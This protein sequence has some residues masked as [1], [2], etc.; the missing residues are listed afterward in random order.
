MPA[1]KLSVLAKAASVALVTLSATAAMAQSVPLSQAEGQRLWFVELSGSPVADGNSQ[2]AVRSEKQ[3]LRRAAAAAG[4]SFTERRSF[5]TLFNGLSIEISTENRLKLSRLAGVKAMYPI[6]TIAAPYVEN[7]GGTAPDLASAI[8]MTGAHIAQASGLT[9]AGIKVGII[10]TGVDLQHPAFRKANGESRVVA[11]YDFVGDNYDA[12]GTGSK[13][14]PQPDD[15]PDDC[16]GHGSHVAG[17]VGGNGT[18]NNGVLIKG[19]APD[20]SFGAYRVFGCEGST[21]SDIILAALERAHADG[22][23]VINQSLG[24]G[25]QWPQYPTAQ[26]S[27]RLA[28][29][30]VVMVASIGNN[31]PGGG[32]PDGLFAAGAP[33]V[34]DKVIGVASFDNTVV[35]QPAFTV[36]PGNQ[37]IGFTAG[38]VPIPTSGSLPMAKT[39]TTTTTNDGCNAL[40][41]GSM[42]G[43][44]VLIR[45]GTC[46]FYNKALNAQR[47]G[48]AAVVLYNNQ[49]GFVTPSLVPVA[50]D[51]TPITIPVVMAS[52]TDGAILDSKIAAGT[53]TLTW[54][55]QV[56]RVAST[57]GGLI[58]GFSSYG[59]TAELNLKPN[60]GAPGGSI[61]SAYPL[62]KGGGASL[63]GTSMSAP[64]VAGAAALMLQAN[65]RLNSQ[66]MMVRLQ[67]SA[68]PKN[69]SGNPNLSFLDFSFR[70]GAGMLD[71]MGSLQATATVEPSQLSL[72]ESEAGPVTRTLT[73]R[74]TGGSAVTFTLSHAPTLA[75]GANTTSG[76]SY[77]IT[78]P[79]SAPATVSFSA[80][81]ITV[82]A[83]GSATVNVTIDANA[84][85]AN[86]AL[87][88][89]YVVLTPEGGGAAYR[90][91]YAGLKGD[92]Q[93]TPILTPTAN[94]FPWLA[95]SAGGNL[96]KQANG[97]TFTMA[98]GDIAYFPIHFD[99]M[100]RK[101]LVE[102]KDAVTGKS[103]QRVSLDEY[104]T[105]NSTPGGFFTW[106][107]DGVTFAG[108]GKNDSQYNV[109]PNGQYVVTF[110][111]L[112]PLGDEANPAHWETWSSPT[113]TIARP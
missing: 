38:A 88:G 103:W 30:G 35:T 58:S 31:G 80:P 95:K 71:I 99:H 85:L 82:P 3:A 34:G 73:V 68:D 47:A 78:G 40:P 77:N 13:L 89:G 62:E 91:P 48:A 100:P 4:I 18:L 29:K 42:N 57:T 41:D 51:T 24:S 20:V 79:F 9:G 7:G 69:W 36:D 81:S 94:G 83:G 90:V 63:S 53:T 75:A 26:A 33:G 111:V 70:Q 54:G 6:D 1:H 66:S 74:N 19:V 61:Y 46:G 93:S 22:M 10:D 28:N 5:D 102:A 65:P 96:T 101:V 8:Q 50:P 12:G 97:A 72:G 25:R 105:R 17:I 104:V 110:S 39:G 67:N 56:A 45:R 23:Q 43:M 44:A 49:A 86:R 106:A 15:N 14:I 112:K 11:G 109:V 37:L 27:S 64:H 84:G 113:I 21:E 2:A 108:K 32:T 59:M 87:Y 107:W 98:N 55:L 92:Y 16:G 60:I 76:A 52:S